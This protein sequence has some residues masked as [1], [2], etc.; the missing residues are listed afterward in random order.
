MSGM[1]GGNEISRRQF[2]RGAPLRA[3]AL[4][5]PGLFAERGNTAETAPDSLHR[6]V[7]A[8]LKV[9]TDW[10]EA[11]GVKGYIGEID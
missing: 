7:R 8:E 6:R 11:N 9:F 10:I 1:S 3:F 4:A 5:T 2:V